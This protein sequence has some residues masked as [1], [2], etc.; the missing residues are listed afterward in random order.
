MRTARGAGGQARPR[1]PLASAWLR[2]KRDRA[3]VAAMLAL[4]LILLISL[5]GGAIATRLLGH[6]GDEPFPYAIVGAGTFTRT[7]SPLT[8]VPDTPNTDMDDYGNIH[9]PPKGTPTTIFWLG[10]DGVLGRDELIRFLDGGR[11]SLEIGL[12]GVLFALLIA[13]P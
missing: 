7:V 10:G 6:S 8:R 5:C 4:A 2:M 13:I 11:T 9:P 1:G 3:T 12:G